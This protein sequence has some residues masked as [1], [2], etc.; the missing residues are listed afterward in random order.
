MSER[1]DA[2]GIILPSSGAVYARDGTL[3]TDFERNPYG[4]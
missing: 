2:R 3:E 4:R 1:L